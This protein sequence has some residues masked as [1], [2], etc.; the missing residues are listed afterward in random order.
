V[1]DPLNILRTEAL[2]SQNDFAN[3]DQQ[4]R[5][6]RHG[7]PEWFHA[8]TSQRN[9]QPQTIPASLNQSKRNGWEIVAIRH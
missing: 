5:S 9:D 2:T 8:T 3:I 1:T 4:R 6:H 7:T